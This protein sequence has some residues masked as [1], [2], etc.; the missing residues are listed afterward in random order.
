[1]IKIKSTKVIKRH[2]FRSIPNHSTHLLRTIHFHGFS[3]HPSQIT[4]HLQPYATYRVDD[5]NALTT[6]HEQAQL[7]P[8]LQRNNGSTFQHPPY[9][10]SICNIDN[11]KDVICPKLCGQLIET[12]DVGHAT[13]SDSFP[14]VRFVSNSDYSGNPLSPEYMVPYAIP[15]ENTTG[16]VNINATKT[17]NLNNNQEAL[18]N[19]HMNSSREPTK[20][21]TQGSDDLT[22]IN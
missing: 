4:N 11:C 18:N 2:M 13:H 8:L 12:A 21:A 3:R 20:Q 16:G 7:N 14:G 9:V 10:R 5:A 22:N 15:V 17:A 6:T 19:V 1:M